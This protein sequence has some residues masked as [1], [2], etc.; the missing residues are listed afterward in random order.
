MEKLK[1]QLKLLFDISEEDA[2]IFLAEFKKKE[3]QKNEV[4]IAEGEVCHIVG[5]I[6]KG[7][8]VCIYNKD[9]EE[10]IDEFGFENNFITNYYSFLTQSPSLKEIRTLEPSV[11]YIIT[12]QS[13]EKLSNQYPFIEKMSRIINEKLFLRA[14]NRIQSLLLESAQERYEKMIAQRPDLG[15]RIP[16]YMLASYLHVKPETISRIRKKISNTTLLT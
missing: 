14:H 3:L 11:V 4:F 12:R 13:L 1:Q 16:Q 15:Q 10:I 2:S 6:Q 9:G 5:L 8:L 7:L